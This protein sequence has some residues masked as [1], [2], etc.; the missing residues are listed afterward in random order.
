LAFVEDHAGGFLPLVLRHQALGPAKLRAALP[1]RRYASDSAFADQLALE[2][3]RTEP[4]RSIG[5]M[6]ELRISARG[7]VPVILAHGHFHL[8]ARG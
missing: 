1:G 7:L 4:R 3:P 8:V 2:G 6:W 5:S